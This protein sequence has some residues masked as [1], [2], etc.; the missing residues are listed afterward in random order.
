MLLAYLEN[1]IGLYNVFS[2]WKAY[3]VTSPHHNARSTIVATIHIQEQLALAPH[4]DESS[5][6]L[7]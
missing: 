4:V 5:H 1:I 6:D 7:N 2:N 3:L